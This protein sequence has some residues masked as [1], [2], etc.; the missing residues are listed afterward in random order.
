VRGDYLC[1]DPNWPATDPKNNKGDCYVGSGRDTRA[2]DGGGEGFLKVSDITAA[3]CNVGALFFALVLG[4]APRVAAPA[5][6][7]GAPV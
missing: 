5:G 1:P 4:G 7:W 3:L 2:A 6:L